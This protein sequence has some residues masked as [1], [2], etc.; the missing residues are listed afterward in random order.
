MQNLIKALRTMQDA[1]N[2]FTDAALRDIR[3][4]IATATMDERTETKPPP[5]VLFA[6]AETNV[7]RFLE[8]LKRGVPEETLS[9]I[10]RM[11]RPSAHAAERVRSVVLQMQITP[12]AAEQ[13]RNERVQQLVRA[14]HVPIGALNFKMRRYASNAV[15]S[16]VGDAALGDAGSFAHDDG[17]ASYMK[18]FDSLT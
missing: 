8:F 16:R 2:A 7:L 1:S 6:T 9:D 4:W 10:A 15:Y 5:S 3:A 18:S 17:E 14:Y 13:Q 11:H 12:Q